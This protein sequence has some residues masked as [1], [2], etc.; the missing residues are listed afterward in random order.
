VYNKKEIN[1]KYTPTWV[2]CNDNSHSTRHR[3]E[4]I[5]KFGGHF[6]KNKI[7]YIW[8]RPKIIRKP[9]NEK[10]INLLNE[11]NEIITITNIRKYCREHK[12]SRARLQE[13]HRGKRKTYKGLRRIPN[14]FFEKKNNELN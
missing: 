8:F 14:D 7:Y 3:R 5:Q 13:I 11:K 1:I 12:L 9:I 2:L 4:F 6:E 10:T